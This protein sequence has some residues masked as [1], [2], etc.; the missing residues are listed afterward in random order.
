VCNLNF[1][2][3]LI[4]NLL[5]FT[6]MKKTFLLLTLLV[7][8]NYVVAQSQWR[9]GL[10]VSPL[11]SFASVTDADK[12][13][14]V[15][16]DASSRLGIGGGLVANYQFEEKF[17]LQT[18]L[19]IVNRG[20]TIKR[21]NIEQKSSITT[22]EIPLLLHL[23]T[24]EIGSGIRATGIF[25]GTAGVFAGAGTDLTVNGTTTSD[26]K[27]AIFN[28]FQFDFTFGAGAEMNLNGAGTVALGLSYHLPLIV[29]ADKVPTVNQGNGN[30]YEYKD[31]RV[32]LGYLALDLTYFF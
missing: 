5:N 19:Q 27:G 15:G 1:A 13:D 31:G 9:L 16:L 32:K 25:G 21:T 6:K 20:Y 26:K 11:V 8:S 24:N 18:G 2:N 7:I 23:R 10:R 17:A 29:M 22:V 12:N 3:P 4:T 28:T 14:I 30:G